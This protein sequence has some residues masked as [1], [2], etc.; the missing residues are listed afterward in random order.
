MRVLVPLLLLLSTPA[1]AV[2]YVQPGGAP[3]IYVPSHNVTVSVF[4]VQTPVGFGI[5]IFEKRGA[6]W[7]LCGQCLVSPEL[8][9]MEAAVNQAGSPAKYVASKREEINAV[10]AS[11]YPASADRK[12]DVTLDSVNK[13]LVDGAVLSLVNGVPQ[14]GTR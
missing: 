3:Q 12:S 6:A 11:R 9:S 7:F 2:D 8:P 1:L 13:A 5:G 10:L 14:L 4:A